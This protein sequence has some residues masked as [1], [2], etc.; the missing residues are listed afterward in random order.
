MNSFSGETLSWSS[1]IKDVHPSSFELKPVLGSGRE[2]RWATV[3]DIFKNQI[4]PLYGSQSALLK[5]VQASKDIKCRLLYEKTT[6][7][8]VYIYT[9]IP[10]QSFSEK[11]FRNCLEIKILYAK[12]LNSEET[13]KTYS[14][15][16]LNQAVDRAK[17]YQADSL[18]IRVAKQALQAKKFFEE[19]QF[20]MVMEDDTLYT[21]AKN[22]ERISNNNNVNMDNIHKAFSTSVL[23]HNEDEDEFGMSNANQEKKEN[24][25]ILPIKKKNKNA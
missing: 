7:V 15:Y 18:F 17:E 12:D 4:E 3:E 5:E 10:S 23:L 1:V 19:H 6:P 2:Q 11:G 9:T 24:L 22:I 14:F 16:L 20:H 21:Y 8:G 25:M 13:N